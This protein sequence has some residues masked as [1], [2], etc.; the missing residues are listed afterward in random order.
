MLKTVRSM[1][2]SKFTA[3]TFLAMLLVGFGLLI[4]LAHEDYITEEK[5]NALKDRYL[6]IEH[7]RNEISQINERMIVAERLKPLMTE[8]KWQNEYGN[9]DKQLMI[10]IAHAKQLAPEIYQ[11]LDGVEAIERLNRLLNHQMESAIALEKSKAHLT[12]LALITVLIV[13]LLAWLVLIRLTRRY[14]EE[15]I[16]AL[17]QQVKDRTQALQETQRQL[18]L[19]EKM[20]AVGQLAA[21]MAHEINN[22]VGFINK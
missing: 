2:L 8:R 11:H 9:L 1:M 13:V 12:K 17:N 19:N 16:V 18:I 14:Q 20:A 3:R 4:V 6:T 22:P 15:L 5:I 7:N 21:G 10:A